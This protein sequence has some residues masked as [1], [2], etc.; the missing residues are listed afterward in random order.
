M[1]ALSASLA[2]LSLAHSEPQ[3][4]VAAVIGASRGIGRAVANTLG[5]SKYTVYCIARSSTQNGLH[6]S[7]TVENTAQSVTSAG[8]KGIPL[9]L[10]LTNYQQLQDAAALIEKQAGRLDLLVYSAYSPPAG[11]LRG[12]FWEQPPEMWDACN[13]VGLKS[14]YLA[15]AVLA[16]LLIQTAQKQ[17]KSDDA[18][19]P[20]LTLVSS[21][22]GRSFTFNV[23]Y[24][25]GKAGIDRLAADMS[26]QL[27]PFGVSTTSLYPGVVRTERNLELDERGLFKEASGGLTLDAS[28]SESPEFT[29]RAV[30]ALS[31]LSRSAMLSRSGR[32]EVVAELAK[33]FGFRD[34]DG[35]IPPS[36]R[37]LRFLLPNFVFPQVEEES[38]K[39]IP[40]WIR[41]NVP[42]VL[43]PWNIFG[44][45]RPDDSAA[46]VG[47][48]ETGKID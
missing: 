13:D 24:G 31:S 32:V 47:V 22:G 17:E 9:P 11:K 25:V 18:P 38:K 30:V 4:R 33:E 19:G 3:P 35:A 8:G 34:V 26:I 20:L 41:E 39:P 10:D 36:I 44:A 5:Q 12:N 23:A 28:A 21:F 6:S 14:A 46:K 43:L 16:P 37:S 15:S 42:D 1:D 2:L 48:Q 7:L 40:N 45:P 29:G 27:K